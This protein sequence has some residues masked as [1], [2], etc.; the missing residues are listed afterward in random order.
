MPEVS[1][2]IPTHNQCE[3]L[4]RTLEALGRQTY[5]LGKLEVIVVADGC[6]DDTIKMLE[7]YEAPYELRVIELWGNGAATAR[8]EG[9]KAATGRFLIFLDDDIE[10][11][12]S[13]IEAH[14]NVHQRQPHAVVIGYLPPVYPEPL[15]FFHLEA[16][17]WW[18]NKFSTMREPGHRFNYLDMLSGN[19]SVPVA[20]FARLGGFDTNF[21]GCGGEDYEFGVRLIKSGARFVHAPEAMGYHHDKTGLDRSFVR[22][23]KEGQADVMIGRRHPELRPILLISKI[24]SPWTPLARILS[25]LAISSPARGDRLAEFFRYVLDSHER[26]R[27]QNR[28][29]KL[30]GV[31]RAYWYWR[32][33]MDELG[34]QDELKKFLN[35]APANNA[36]ADHQ[37]DIDLR[38]GLELA[39]RRLNKERPAKARLRYGHQHIGDVPMQLGAERLRGEHLRPILAK[40]FTWPLLV[41]MA[42]EDGA[43]QRVNDSTNGAMRLFDSPA[44]TPSQ[45]PHSIPA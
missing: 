19:F 15:D 3:A 21:P 5:P 25:K 16:R 18:E 23:R 30:Y 20:L 22:A 43:W 11:M 45:K 39:E 4:R 13:L 27:R 26:W 7:S 10:S 41:A 36:G 9:A 31:L 17:T 34:N 14:I 35:E 42:S 38:A 40:N 12:P 32:G 1:L 29:R 6:I 2:I 44:S 8:N 33:A 28:W 24:N 37:L